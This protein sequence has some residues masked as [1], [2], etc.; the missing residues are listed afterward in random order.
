MNIVRTTSDDKKTVLNESVPRTV[1]SLRGMPLLTPGKDT[2][3]RL[4]GSGIAR[5][6]R[7]DNMSA[8]A[9]IS[10]FGQYGRGVT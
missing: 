2:P 6:V 1:T 3:D 4:R 5:A 9:H 10:R 8:P 7:T